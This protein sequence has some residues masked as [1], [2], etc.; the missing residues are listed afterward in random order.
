[1]VEKGAAKIVRDVEAKEKMLQ[2]AL[3][4][5]GNEAMAFSLSEAIHQLARPDAAQAIAREVIHLYTFHTDHQTK[6]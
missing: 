3:M 6:K 1:L 4:V 5:L 2:E